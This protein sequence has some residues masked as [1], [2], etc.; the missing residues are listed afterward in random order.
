MKI[1]LTGATPGR[2]IASLRQMATKRIGASSYAAI[3]PEV[4]SA[5]ERGEY[6][7]ATHVE[8]MAVDMQRLADA[9]F[10]P[11]APTP[12]LSQS[13]FI[14]RMR[15][16]GD[17]VYELF[18]D[19][20]WD[21]APTWKSDIAR[22]WAAM[23]VGSSPIG[24]EEAIH[25]AAAAAEDRHFGVR[26]FAWLGIRTR[27]REDTARAIDL[28]LP[29]ASS[30]S[31]FR[32]RFAIEVTRPISVWGVHLPELKSN[33]GLALPLVDQYMCEPN[34]YAARSTTNWLRDSRRSTPGWV[35]AVVRDWTTSCKCAATSRICAPLRR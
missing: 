11:L 24:L 15:A 12:D 2:S 10:G 1:A 25:R 34:P 13:S 7:C 14:G 28:L 30:E 33:P 6:E 22:C 3:T 18:G 16:G 17:L 35:S 19:Q 20:L 31:A 27:V 5:L 23:A 29:L 8:Q 4:L 26:E 9:L 21:V 32:R